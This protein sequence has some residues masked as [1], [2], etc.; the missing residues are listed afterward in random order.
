MRFHQLTLLI[1]SLPKYLRQHV[2]Y[3]FFY[4]KQVY[5][6]NAGK[7]RSSIHYSLKIFHLHLLR[8]SKVNISEICIRLFCKHWNIYISEAQPWQWWFLKYISISTRLETK[9]HLLEF[10]KQKSILFSLLNNLYTKCTRKFHS[11]NNN[12]PANKQ[13]THLWFHH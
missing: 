12:S 3:P 1:K 6:T 7:P 9:L 4:H 11:S 13:Y 10:Q 2:L 8:R 5:T